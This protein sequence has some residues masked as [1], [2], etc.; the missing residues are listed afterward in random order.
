[1]ITVHTHEIFNMLSS[2]IKI[3]VKDFQSIESAEICVEGLT[4]IIGESSS[5]KSAIMRAV[6]STVFNRFYTG[7]VHHG[8]SFTGIS[9]SDSQAKVICK[10]GISGSP[11]YKVI[12]DGSEST[13]S[14]IGRDV[15]DVIKSIFNMDDFT[16]GNETWSVNFYSQFENPIL[17]SFSQKKVID[18]LSSS[19]EMVKCEALQKKIHSKFLEDKGISVGYTTLLSENA[20]KISELRDTINKQK[21]LIEQLSSFYSEYVALKKSLL[22]VEELSSVTNTLISL[23]SQIQ[24]LEQLLTQ[25]S[26]YKE[27]YDAYNS[28]S[29][30][31]KD[32]SSK[33]DLNTLIH[34][35]N[36]YSAVENQVFILDSIRNV[37][38][39][40]GNVLTGINECNSVLKNHKCP[41]CNSVVNVEV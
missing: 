24:D 32:L 37:D 22:L 18:I 13:F 5:G 26:L 35:L 29:S 30:L 34:S 19:P 41:I 25:F 40:I 23:H 1:M 33:E 36:E 15:P 20:A 21:P 7:C 38:M 10:K 16:S 17:M 2:M 6:K 27:A 12:N 9:F 11:S 28:L 14:K 39:L 8:S 4:M 3:K 31:I